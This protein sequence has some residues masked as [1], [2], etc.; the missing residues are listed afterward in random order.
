M[1]KTH[2]MSGTSEY[3]SWCHL[4]ERC[5]NPNCKNYDDYGG[6]GIKVCDEWKDDF[7]AF[8]NHVGDKPSS[9][10]S[11]HRIENDGNYEPGNVKW[12]T[13][14]EQNRDKRTTIWL[15][16]RG[17]TK[18]LPDWCD[19]LGLDASTIRAR[20]QAY[21][22]DTE[23]ALTE[24]IKNETRY[25]EYDGQYYTIK[26]LADKYNV[27]KFLLKNRFNQGWSVQ[28]ALTTP[29]NDYL[30]SFTYN[31]KTQNL[32]AWAEEFN[33]PKTSLFRRINDHKMSI[34]EAL[35][36]EPPDKR[37]TFNGKSQ[38]LPQWAREL[39]INVETL[40]Q[41]IKYHNYTIEEAFTTP[42][43]KQSKTHRRS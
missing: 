41:R 4:K 31:G 6:R 32:T 40:R 1:P 37:I 25:F 27:C 30:T 35:T 3:K 26:E 21:G 12:A 20:I 28:K 19:E 33:I 5:L 14:E 23:R 11:I 36:Y 34:E 7:A 13:A 38:T 29:Y 15:E 24:K 43:K 8:Y 9:E 16:F 39:N 10:H 17:K 18:S 42:L 2:Q 22:W